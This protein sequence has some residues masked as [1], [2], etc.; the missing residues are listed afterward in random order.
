MSDGLSIMLFVILIVLRLP[1]KT[2][3]AVECDSVAQ[4]LARVAAAAAAAAIIAIP[5]L[6]WQCAT[7][8]PLCWKTMFLR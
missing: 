6:R 7:Q 8:Q 5:S 2:Y 3:I 1:V 4:R